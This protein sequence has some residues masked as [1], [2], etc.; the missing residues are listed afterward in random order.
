MKHTTPVGVGIVGCGDISAWYLKNL[1]AFSILN[2]VACCDLN[3]ALAQACAAEHGLRVMTFEEMLK[4]DEIELILN[5]TPPSAHYP[6]NRAALMAGKHVYTEK[7]LADSLEKAEELVAL[8][9]EKNLY[10]GCAPDSFL[11]GSFQTARQVVEAGLIGE[12]YA[13]RALVVRG[14]KPTGEKPLQNAFI[15]QPMGGIP[16]DMS[17]YYLHALVNILGPVEKVCGFAQTRQAT[18]RVVNP[19]NADFGSDI[20]VRTENNMAGSL[21]FKNG[22]LGSIV[23]AAEGFGETSELY[24]YGTEGVLKLGNPNQYGEPCVLLRENCEPCTLPLTHGYITEFRGLGMAEM[25]WALRQGRPARADAQLGLHALEVI[26]GMVESSESGQ[27]Y[28]LR[29]SAEKPAA[30]LSGHVDGT[31]QEYVLTQG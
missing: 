22:V 25:A 23:F 14:Y 5:I 28:T 17:G 8:A 11:G 3:E 9:K 21:Q 30:F 29:N 24:I 27:T 19:R 26:T 13:C 6:L 4:S 31:A 1:P 10:L 2:V 16:F 15:F 12:P 20:T 18:R 7:V